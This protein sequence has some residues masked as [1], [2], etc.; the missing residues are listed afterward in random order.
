MIG[1]FNVM[2]LIRH[3]TAE[4]ASDKPPQHGTERIAKDVVHV[5]ATVRERIDPEQARKLSRLD[6]NGSRQRKKKRRRKVHPQKSFGNEPQRHKE[7]HIE[8]YLEDGLE[9]IFGDVSYE[10]ERNQI[11][12]NAIRNAGS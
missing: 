2:H 12:W 9:S 7:H 4:R 10:V 11:G 1:D 5:K 8:Q 6:E 3:C